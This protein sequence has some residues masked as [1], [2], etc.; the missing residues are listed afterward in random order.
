VEGFAPGVLALAAVEGRV[1]G[2]QLDVGGGV[3][4][5]GRVAGS[6]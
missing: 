2:E 1:D 5:A 3:A 4:A 6:R